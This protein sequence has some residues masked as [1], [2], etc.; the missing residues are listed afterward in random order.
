MPQ[1]IPGKLYRLVPI[2]TVSPERQKA[3]LESGK[4]METLTV[5]WIVYGRNSANTSWTALNP[6]PDGAILLYL[7]IYSSPY[8]SSDGPGQPEIAT[9]LYKEKMLLAWPEA[10]EEIDY[11]SV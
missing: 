4:M 8:A 10:L 1:L 3:L 7:G 11:T 5:S 9:V 6:L 2:K